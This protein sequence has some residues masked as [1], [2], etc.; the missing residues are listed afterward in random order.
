[1]PDLK[2][3]L[4]KYLKSKIKEGHVFFKSKYIAEDLGET[5]KCISQILMGFSKKESISGLNIRK[6]S[7]A[8]GITWCITKFQNRKRGDLK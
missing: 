4:I 2:N 8:L 7:R 6:R 5:T 1:M 3:R